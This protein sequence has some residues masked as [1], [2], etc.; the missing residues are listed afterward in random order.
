MSA[1]AQAGRLVDEL[2]S[3]CFQPLQLTLDVRNTVS[4]V[5]QP[6]PAFVQELLHGRIGTGGLQKLDSGRPGADKCDVDLLG[7]Y[8]LDW[9]TGGVRQEFEKW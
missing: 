4:D 9:G 5:V 3:C 2:D 7:L 6:R 8:A 1:R